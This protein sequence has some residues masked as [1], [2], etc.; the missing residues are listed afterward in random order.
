MKPHHLVPTALATLALAACAPTASTPVEPSLS[1]A[2][3]ADADRPPPELRTKPNGDLEVVFESGCVA[4]FDLNG[5]LIMG[6]RACDDIDIARA[7]A[8][9]RAHLA[10]QNADFSDV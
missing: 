2:A 8:A 10:E 7:R 3:A 5:K 6:G 4:I 1:P 9:V